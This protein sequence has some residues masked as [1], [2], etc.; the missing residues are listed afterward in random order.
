MGRE[1]NLANIVQVVDQ[2]SP[3]LGAGKGWQ[4]HGRQDGNDGD[5]HEEFDQR[6]A[7]A[8]SPCHA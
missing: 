5:H 2:V 4:E 7:G 6:E 3:V 1:E 8:F